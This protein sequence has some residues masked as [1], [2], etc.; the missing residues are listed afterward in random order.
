MLSF[1]FLV[2]LS[3]LNYVLTHLYPLVETNLGHVLFIPASPFEYEL[4]VIALQITCKL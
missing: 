1:C 3:M 2:I 4:Y